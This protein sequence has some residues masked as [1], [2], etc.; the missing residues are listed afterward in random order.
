MWRRIIRPGS[1]L[2]FIPSSLLSSLVSL[3]LS[4]VFRFTLFLWYL[5]V[6]CLLWYLSACSLPLVFSRRVNFRFLS[7]WSLW[8]SSSFISLASL[9]WITGVNIGAYTFQL[10]IRKKERKRERIDLGS[11]NDLTWLIIKCVTNYSFLFQKLEWIQPSLCEYNYLCVRR[12]GTRKKKPKR[13]WFEEEEETE[14]LDL[15]RKERRKYLPSR[16]CLIREGN[17]LSSSSTLSF[18]HSSTLSFLSLHIVYSFSLGIMADTSSHT[19]ANVE[20]CKNY[21]V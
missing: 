9:D 6:Y 8:F 19:E 7:S 1:Q 18:F 15:K 13:T 16:Q 12:R 10:C 20:V 14:E 3:F 11:E 5:S 21:I 4:G 2:I 17:S